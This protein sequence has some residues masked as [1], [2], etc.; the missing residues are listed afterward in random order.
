MGVSEA[1]RRLGADLVAG[2]DAVSAP[3]L[4]HGGQRILFANP[5]MQRLLGYD[6]LQLQA[7]AHDGWAKPDDAP[8]LKHYGERCLAEPGQLPALECEAMTASGSTRSL[9]ITGRTLDLPNGRLALLT[10]QDLSDMRHVQNS[11]LDM[12]RVMH[13]ILESNP[14][15]TLVIDAQHRVTH[16]NAACA[17][18]TG[19]AAVD[20]VGRTDAWRLFYEQERPSLADLIVDGR[21]E[22]ERERLYGS[23]LKPSLLVANAYE[24]EAFFPHLGAQ[25]RWIFFT[26]A[27]LVDPQGV[28]IGAIETLLDVSERRIAEDELKRHQ[29]ELEDIVAART[30][31]LLRS[32]HDLEAF[33]ESASVGIVCS[34]KSMLVRSNKK[35][36]EIFELGEGASAVGM[37]ARRFF[38][39]DAAY[40][41]LIRTA[42]PRLSQGQSLAHEMEM[43]TAN[44][45]PIWVQLIAYPS[46]P[47]RDDSGVWWLLQDRSEE[48]RAQA[49]LVKNYHDIQQ[50]HARLEEAQN[51]LLQSEK[52]ASIGQLAAGVAHEINNPI[53]FVSSNLG[54]LRRYVEPLLELVTLYGSVDLAG[55]TPALQTQLKQ[56]QQAADLDF[57]QQDLPQLLSESEEGLNRVKKIVQDLKDFSRIDQA[58]WQ[59]ADINQGLESTLNVVQHE[60]KYGAD[61]RRDYGQLPPVRCLAGQVNQVFMNLIVNAS[62]AIGMMNSRSSAT[63]QKPRGTITLRSHC[64]GEWVCI[65]VAD[66]GC[67]MSAEV[68]RRIFDPFFTTK[69]VGQG[70]GLGLSLSFSIVKKHGGRI[71]LESAPDQGSCFK[72]WLPIRG[73]GVYDETQFFHCPTRYEAF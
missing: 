39:T 5:A 18:L 57:I 8:R 29:L 17:Q 14:V 66:N 34:N 2:L 33:L 72:V 28:V 51:Q 4:V 37:L 69:P 56:L 1:I 65:E 16:W 59:E 32:N 58:D 3:V 43:V 25:G 36:A 48:T 11:L 68:Q 31:E 70:T 46:D 27:P 21:V 38:A 23:G 71:E 12:G 62:Q 67:G 61:V 44:G 64:D 26:A 40:G 10:C 24:K 19:T 54:T 52:M 30:A 41:E 7:M 53:G 22:A 9:E 13:Q 15:P 20:M 47:E 63:A 55:T 42:L 49:E 50:A 60:I 35:F 6:L 45:R 73:P